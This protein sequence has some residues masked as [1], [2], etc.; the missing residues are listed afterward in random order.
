MDTRSMTSEPT[1][2]T[3]QD[4]W[5][6]DRRYVL[7]LATRMLG[8]PAAAEDVVQE[9]FDRLLQVQLSEI[10]DVRG[11]LAVVVRRL[12]LNRFRSAYM[13]R[14]S[15]VGTTPPEGMAAAS[16]RPRPPRSIRPTARRS[17]TRCAK[18]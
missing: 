9:A 15:A 16:G 17:T 8:D 18:P 11:W 13:R 1:P 4:V 2:L 10:D 14:E 6:D 12:C 5:R 7:G 3:F